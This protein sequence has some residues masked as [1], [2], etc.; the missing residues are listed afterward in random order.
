MTD[1]Q[2]SSAGTRDAI[3]T[4]LE[5]E[6]YFLRFEETYDYGDAVERIMALIP[7]DAQSVG[8]TVESVAAI[9]DPVAFD[10]IS[11]SDKHPGWECRREQAT[12]TAKKIVALS[13]PEQEPAAW[14]YRFNVGGWL[15]WHEL[16]SPIDW[17]RQKHQFNLENGT[18]E[19]RPL[20]AAQPPASPP[21]SSAATAQPHISFLRE[22]ANYF[23]NRPTNGE[24]SAFWSN[25]TN[26]DNCEKAANL[27]ERLMSAV[28][29]GVR[30]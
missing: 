19:L 9:I 21:S 26:A 6:V 16:D 25:V 15:P 14:Q 4:I 12:E 3:Q 11:L 10:P 29:Q 30:K 1:H 24:D 23:R 28:P 8:M 22:A 20:Y 18:C 27:I 5:D 13:Q 2:N 7:T 17:F